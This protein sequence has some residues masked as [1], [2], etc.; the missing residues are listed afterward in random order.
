[1]TGLTGASGMTGVTGAS[2]ATGMGASETGS[3]SV[4]VPTL[5]LL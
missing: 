3:A 2:G 1:M 4:W 5:P